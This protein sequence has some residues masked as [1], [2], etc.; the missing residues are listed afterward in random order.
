MT[1]EN[2]KKIKKKNKKKPPPKIQDIV[3]EESPGPDPELE[4]SIL[5]GM[6]TSDAVLRGVHHI[7]RKE[8]FVSPKTRTIAQWCIDYLEKHNK[9]PDTHIQDIFYFHEKHNR[10][11]P[12]IAEG[13]ER[14]LIELARESEERNTL[15]EEYILDRAEEYFKG[16]SL[17]LLSANMNAAVDLGDPTKAEHILGSY[18]A[19]QRPT[20]KAANPFEID[21]DTLIDSFNMEKDILF[22]FPGQ[23][24]EFLGPFTRD[25]FAAFMGPEKRGKSFWLLECALQ[26]VKARCCVALF[27]VGDM[28]LK[29][30]MRRCWV[31][32]HKKHYKKKYCKELLIPV[33]D[34][35]RNQLGTCRSKHRASQVD[36]VYG[37]DGKQTRNQILKYEDAPREY[38]PCIWCLRNEPEKRKW[39]GAVWYKERDRIQ[40]LNWR[41]VYKSSKRLMKR[42]GYNRF[43]IESYPNRTINIGG[44]RGRLDFWERQEGF[45]PDVIVIDYADVLAP[46]DPRKEPRHQENERWQALRALSQE[47]YCCVIT[48]TQADAKSYRVNDITEENF[49]ED[50]RKFGHVNLGVFTLNQ[51]PTEKAEKVM[52][53]GKMFVRDDEFDTRTF[54]TVLQCLQ[55]GRPYLG[56]FYGKKLIVGE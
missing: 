23:L 5:I 43:R 3:E 33:L 4:R 24:G 25:G 54:C 49:S 42:M 19:V 14:F 21:K 6:I 2:R 51:T 31:H 47:R 8:F 20:G 34:C 30:V 41:E 7:Y 56:S 9:A 11:S 52:R 32:T 55:I 37:L 16:R 46:E 15:N 38:K 13:I 53:I 36:V 44:L 17:K 39:Q 29:Q 40:P 22:H 10:I 1:T 27:T 45:V 48:A 50:K 28:S 12:E 18:K 35:K 26:A